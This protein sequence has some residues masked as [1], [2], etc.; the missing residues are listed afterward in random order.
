MSQTKVQ[1][2]HEYRSDY[3][4][5]ISEVTKLLKIDTSIPKEEFQENVEKAYIILSE[6]DK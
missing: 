3:D 5:K 6:D 2:R 1:K 4:R